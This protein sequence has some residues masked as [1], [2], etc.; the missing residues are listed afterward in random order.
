VLKEDWGKNHDLFLS[1]VTSLGRGQVTYRSKVLPK[2]ASEL[3]IGMSFISC[4]Y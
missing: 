4:T 1:V 2:S 3:R